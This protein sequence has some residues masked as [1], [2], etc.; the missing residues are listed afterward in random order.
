MSYNMEKKNILIFSYLFS[1]I[2]ESTET[3][4]TGPGICCLFIKQ[5]VCEQEERTEA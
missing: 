5:A 1:N 4:P 2:A 3:E